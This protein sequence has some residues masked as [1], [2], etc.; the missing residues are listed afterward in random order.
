MDFATAKRIAS[1]ACR[2]LG[3][4]VSGDVSS[5]PLV[6][7]PSTF[8]IKCQNN[9]G[10][11]LGLRRFDNGTWDVTFNTQGSGGRVITL[12]D[13]EANPEKLKEAQYRICYCLRIRAL[14]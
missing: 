11:R 12:Q 2:S 3:H 14:L 4:K 5:Y 8:T 13:Y 9:C 1:L 6:K 10:V 7:N